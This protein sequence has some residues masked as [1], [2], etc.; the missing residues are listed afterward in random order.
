MSNRRATKQSNE[1]LGLRVEDNST[2]ST[3][4][5]SVDAWR[6]LAMKKRNTKIT[7]TTKTAKARRSEG[8][9]KPIFTTTT[10]CR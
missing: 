8:S 7:E 5:S 6:A 3:I 1:G 9:K 4:T 2:P 10:I